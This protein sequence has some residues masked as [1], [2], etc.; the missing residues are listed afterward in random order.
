MCPG[1]LT[2]VLVGWGLKCSDIA[3]KEWALVITLH[4]HYQ[5]LFYKKAVQV[6]VCHE[7]TADRLLSF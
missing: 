1:D 4:N 7:H 3:R 2:C 5:I 6:Q